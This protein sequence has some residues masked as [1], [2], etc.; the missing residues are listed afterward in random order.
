MNMVRRLLI[1]GYSFLF[2]A[3]AIATTIMFP[4]STDPQGDESFRQDSRSFY[5]DAYAKAGGSDKDSVYKESA[6][7][8]TLRTG[9]PEIV[10]NFVNRYRLKD[11]KVLDVGAGSGLLQD[12]VEDYTG[13]DIAASA[14]RF[15]HKPFVEASA[16]NMPFPDNTFDAL[17]SFR[18]L[19]HIPNP[20]RALL[21]MRRVVKSGGYILLDVANDVDRYAAQGYRVRPYSE[22]DIWGKIKKATI[23]IADSN[24]IIN[25]Y[26]HQIRLLRSL[27]SRFGN[28]PSRLHFTK[29]EA[30]YD[31]YWIGDSDACTAVSYHELYRW[32]TSRGDHCD[33]CPSEWDLILDITRHDNA[34]VIRITK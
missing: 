4:W 19:E 13:L 23:P 24:A 1:L 21:E 27:G 16:T 18:V 29:I 3:M 31:Y 10:A 32:F 8:S 20:E 5:D 25:L 14:R 30:N 6:E 15:F 22:F 26:T 33:N 2:L 11:K 12:S 9:T 17:W 28:G 34:M 7:R